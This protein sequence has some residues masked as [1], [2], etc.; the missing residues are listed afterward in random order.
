MIPLTIFAEYQHRASACTWAVNM[1]TRNQ[2]IWS[3]EPLT[4]IKSAFLSPPILNP[5]NHRN[6]VLINKTINKTLEGN[7]SFLTSTWSILVHVDSKRWHNSDPRAQLLRDSE[8]CWSGSSLQINCGIGT[9]TKTG[10]RMTGFLPVKW[11]SYVNW[12]HL[13]LRI[14][15]K[16]DSQAPINNTPVYTHE[17]E[18]D[19]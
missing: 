8:H 6:H 14:K 10:S 4:T 2:I 9:N 1:M 3:L 12:S 15:N 19:Y 5:G 17:S 16:T 18:F 13:L 11:V 7:L